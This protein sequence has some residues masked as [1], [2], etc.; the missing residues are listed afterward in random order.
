MEHV[1]LGAGYTR[2]G[3]AIA[4]NYLCMW[5]QNRCVSCDELWAAGSLGERA[6]GSCQ[7]HGEKEN[8]GGWVTGQRALKIHQLSVLGLEQRAMCV[9]VIDCSIVKGFMPSVVTLRYLPTVLDMR[10]TLLLGV[11]VAEFFSCDPR[12]GLSAPR[13]ML[14]TVLYRQCGQSTLVAPPLTFLIANMDHRWFW[15][16]PAGAF[17]WIWGSPENW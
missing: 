6:A 14:P 12:E 4:S 8:D 3:D 10:P 1:V 17:L 9:R 2:T 11:G 13:L 15:R 16:V 7:L 5:W